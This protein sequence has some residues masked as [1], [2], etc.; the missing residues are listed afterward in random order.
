MRYAVIVGHGILFISVSRTLM[1]VDQL[2]KK[3]EEVFQ[4]CRAFCIFVVLLYNLLR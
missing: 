2:R 4:K 1:N 3:V